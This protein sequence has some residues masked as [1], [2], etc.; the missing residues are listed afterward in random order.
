MTNGIHDRGNRRLTGLALAVCLSALA[1][2]GTTLA[3]DYRIGDLK[4]DHP[5]T[6]ATP[7]GAKAA[8][9]FM[10]ITNTG[11]TRDVLIGGSLVGAG[12]VEVHEM[13]MEK[14]IMRMRRLDPGLVIEPGQTIELKPGSYHVMFMQLTTS[15]KEGDKVKGTLVFERA[16]KVEVEFK[17]ES[18]AA[19]SSGGHGHH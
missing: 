15:F 6:R 19:R 1:F 12:V 10:K 2:A 3:H 7:G 11:K 18:I 9:G 4:I 17:I 8:G 14:D 16:G 13:R 5:W